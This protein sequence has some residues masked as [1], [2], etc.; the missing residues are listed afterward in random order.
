MLNICFEST[1]YICEL[2]LV[3]SPPS[4]SNLPNFELRI[5]IPHSWLRTMVLNWGGGGR[6]FA[7]Q[8]TSGHVYRHFYL[9]QL[10][11]AGGLKRRMLLYILA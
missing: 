3:F 8:G 6:D 10:K 4:A 5:I 1:G 2:V 9:S 7:P 11:G